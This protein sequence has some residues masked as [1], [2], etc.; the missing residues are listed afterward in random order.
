MVTWY[1]AL[2]LQ[3]GIKWYIAMRIQTGTTVGSTDT[4]SWY[5]DT[6]HW[7]YKLV[8][9]NAALIL[10]AGTTIRST[11]N[12]SW[13]HFTKH[14]YNK[15]VPRYAAL[16]LQAGTAE[17]STDTTRRY[18]GT[19]QLLQA[20]T[21]VYNSIDTTS[22]YHSIPY[23]QHWYYKLVP[24]R[25]HGVWYYKLASRHNMYTKLILQAATV[26]GTTDTASQYYGTQCT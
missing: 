22:W 12:T 21:T 18:Q 23:I 26:V 20:G 25:Q 6:Q 1:T 8:P 5:H 19:A 13:Y 24:G 3:S 10:Q 4:I 14:W 16:I 2:R 7:Y 17:H 9:R 15:L 11:D